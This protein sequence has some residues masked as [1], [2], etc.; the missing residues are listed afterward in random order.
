MKNAIGTTRRRL[1][2]PIKRQKFNDRHTA[3]REPRELR[4]QSGPRAENVCCSGSPPSLEHP[5]Q[6]LCLVSVPGRGAKGALERGGGR[7][8]DTHS[9]APPAPSRAA[10]SC[11]QL[12]RTRAEFLACGGGGS[13][14]AVP[15]LV[16][17]MALQTAQGRGSE[18]SERGELLRGFCPA[19]ASLNSYECVASDKPRTTSLISSPSQPTYATFSSTRR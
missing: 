19:I 9:G 1:T 10:S 17:S 6:S 13:F 5:P 2:P 11:H 14:P 15:I 7:R 18:N 12:D 16:S 3:S 8:L 4:P